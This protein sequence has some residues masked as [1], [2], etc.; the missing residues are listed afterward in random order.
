MFQAEVVHIS[1]EMMLAR[2]RGVTRHEATEAVASVKK[3]VW[4]CKNFAAC[5]LGAEDMTFCTNKICYRVLFKFETA[6]VNSLILNFSARSWHV[7]HLQDTWLEKPT[8]D[9]QVRWS[10]HLRERKRS[11]YLFCNVLGKKVVLQ[12]YGVPFGVRDLFFSSGHL[13]VI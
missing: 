12:K 5:R 2:L 7:K 8:A 6:C 4:R 3:R 10:H 9:C 1:S 11:N 13:P